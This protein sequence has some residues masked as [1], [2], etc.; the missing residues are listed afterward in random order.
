MRALILEYF[1]TGF[2]NPRWPYVP[3]EFNLEI[4][5]KVESLRQ[6]VLLSQPLPP[7]QYDLSPRRSPAAGTGL[8]E[9][10]V[11]HPE[12]KQTEQGELSLLGPV[13]MAFCTLIG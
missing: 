2:Y 4:K 3:E 12:T 8:D 6:E 9:P 1:Y 5:I 10:G 7:P 11:P 13:L